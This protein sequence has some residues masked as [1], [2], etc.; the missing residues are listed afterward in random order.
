MVFSVHLNGTSPVY[1]LEIPYT[2][3]GSADGTDHDLTD[4]VVVMESG[5]DV[6]VRFSVFPD[7]DVEGLEN[8]TVTLSDELNIGNKFSHEI[9]IREDNV[10]PDVDLFTEQ[11]GESRILVVPTGSDVMVSSTVNHPDPTNTYDFDWV[12][13]DVELTDIDNTH[14]TFTFDPSGLE[15]GVYRIRATVTDADDIAFTDSDTLYVQVV[16][17]L[18]SPA[19]LDSD[20]DGVP[21]I[22]D[23]LA[24]T[25][26]DGILDYLDP[27]PECNV[28]PQEVAFVDGYM[29]E[30]DPGV[31]L[32]LGNFSVSS[33]LGGA[34]VIDEDIANDDDIVAD[35]EATNIGGI[36]DFIAY[37]LPEAGQSLNIV[38]PQLKPIPANAVYR[39]F[40]P[41]GGWVTFT[42][43]S[44]NRLWSVEGEPG[45]CPPP[46]GDYWTPGLTEGHW[47]VQLEIVDGSIN[48]DDG[49]INGT[50]VDPGGVGVLFNGNTQPIAE[51]DALTMVVDETLFIDVLDNDSDA[52][53]DALSITSATPSFGTAVIENGGITFTPPAGFIGEVTIV[54]GISD[55]QGGS[56][57]A[58]VVITIIGNTPPVAVN[59]AVTI[60]VDQSITVDVLNNDFDDDGD[61]IR[62][63]S[64]STETGVAVVNPDNTITYTPPVGYTGVAIVD[65]VIED[66]QG[67][68][69]AGRLQVTVQPVTVRI[70]NS[71]GGGGSIGFLLLL[72]V[73]GV[74][75]RQYAATTYN[76]GLK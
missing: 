9:T 19:E 44:N 16:D 47:C 46:G 71:G 7:A 75:G 1:P 20:G 32:R 3:A 4:D 6:S 27:T 63:V 76:K 54:Y 49:L 17:E 40:T 35:P 10:N 60:D 56:D 58:Q 31:C 15:A 21:D 22:V 23:G 55:G 48:D 62:V 61:S 33:E 14:D 66:T 50:I 68:T 39:K 69:S 26:R 29:V 12:S 64:V 13:L 38:M 8:I 57:V 53:N 5:S 73:C 59:D 67:G 51:D 30:G 25:D 72:L 34:K 52:D 70:E 43:D 45:Y 37:G 42:E 41:E 36:F 2:V 24:D 11:D 74:I 18:P 65:Y 28:L